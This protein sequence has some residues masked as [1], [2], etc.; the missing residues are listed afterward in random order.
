V[1]EDVP[2][3]LVP[4]HEAIA[5]GAV[6]PLHLGRLEG[7]FRNGHPVRAAVTG[8]EAVPPAAVIS[9]AAISLAI[10][11]AVPAETRVAPL[12]TPHLEGLSRALVEIMD[13]G[14]LPPLETT[15]D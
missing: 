15:N 10:V 7:T 1:D 13:F 2:G 14:N 8:L 4:D 12:E 5:L 6:E 9:I 11:I 3:L